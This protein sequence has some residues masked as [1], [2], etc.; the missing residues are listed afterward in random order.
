MAMPDDQS[1]INT[2]PATLRDSG[3]ESLL[4]PTLDRAAEAVETVHKSL[5]ADLLRIPEVA[6]FSQ[7]FIFHRWLGAMALNSLNVVWA[8][9]A[10]TGRRCTRT[11]L[12]IDAYSNG[13]GTT[14]RRAATAIIPVEEL[15]PYIPVG[16]ERFIDIDSPKVADGLAAYLGKNKLMPGNMIYSHLDE[17]INDDNTVMCQGKRVSFRPTSTIRFVTD[18]VSVKDKKAA[19]CRIISELA[20]LLRFAGEPSQEAL[21]KDL[22]AIF[23]VSDGRYDSLYDAFEQTR[24][25]VATL[26]DIARLGTARGIDVLTQ[27]ESGQR[28]NGK[29]QRDYG[30]SA[31]IEKQRCETI[32]ALEHIVARHIK[33]P[34]EVFEY[35]VKSPESLASKVLL[36]RLHGRIVEYV[37]DGTLN[38]YLEGSGFK[39]LTEDD[40]KNRRDLRDMIRMAWVVHGDSDAYDIRPDNPGIVP[41]NEDEA[42]LTK[43]WRGVYLFGIPPE[44]RGI[45]EDGTQRWRGLGWTASRDG[46]TVNWNETTDV[47]D[48]ITHPKRNG[49]RELKMYALMLGTRTAF[50]IQMMTNF[51]NNLNRF[52]DDSDH[53][54][55][56]EKNDAII[57]FCI[58]KGDISRERAN[59]IRLTLTSSVEILR[60][61][62][63][64]I[65]DVQATAAPYALWA[66]S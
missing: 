30:K 9:R 63:G 43:V 24:F 20:E 27:F 3:L 19:E 59:A 54:E 6:S 62:Q 65:R 10:A 32:K 18:R 21:R 45:G 36:H 34:Y 17:K 33:P 40:V 57:E 42:A 26:D 50:E 58:E 61:N 64:R 16:E 23:H 60:W 13:H 2:D 49:F 4:G 44:Y 28:L 53:E 8:N 55:F 7:E 37:K 48:Y 11:Y 46:V 39:P 22:K 31:G 38:A 51:M 29:R 25:F 14:G 15:T 35:G 5:A 52:S 66:Q 41:K 56:K 1:S 12:R 47:K